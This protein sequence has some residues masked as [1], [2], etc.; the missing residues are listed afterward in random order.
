MMNTD[1][2]P[3]ITY[4][5]FVRRKEKKQKTNW[6]TLLYAKTHFYNTNDNGRHE[7]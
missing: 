6:N 7:N 5:I 1:L 2:M 3:Y 4:T